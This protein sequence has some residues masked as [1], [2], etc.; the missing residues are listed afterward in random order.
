MHL[1]HALWDKELR[2]DLKQVKVRGRP[3]HHI[4][5][6]SRPFQAFVNIKNRGHKRGLIKQGDIT[7]MFENK[8][9]ICILDET[10][11]GRRNRR[12]DALR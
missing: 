2:Q 5:R 6:Q 11:Y 8:K 10:V 3:Q 1:I 12:D 9:E 4:G 7:K